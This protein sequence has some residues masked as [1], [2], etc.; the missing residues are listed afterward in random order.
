M[1]PA[2]SKWPLM[3]SVGN[4]EY[5]YTKEGDESK[6]PSGPDG[7]Y[8]PRWGNY[9]LDSGGE[10]GVPTA[11]RFHMP[12]TGNGVFWYSY[13]SGLVHTIVLSTEHDLSLH[14]RQRQ[15]LVED[16]MSVDRSR[17]PWVVL[18][19]HRPLY[20]GEA[21]WA[22]NNVGIALRMEVEDVLYDFRVDIVLAGHYHAYHRTYVG[23]GTL[24]R[25]QSLSSLFYCRCDGLY[26]DVCNQEG[27]VHLTIG[28]AGAR[29]DAANVNLL[30]ESW[31]ENMILQTYGYGRITVYNA[32]ALHFQFIQHGSSDD[33]SA[34]K[35]LDEIWIKR[36]RS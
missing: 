36:E 1:E 26:R 29:L 6:D 27:P 23:V 11:K 21:I 8:E 24:W 9:G 14:S 31:T 30:D 18:E 17:T 2:A 3:V 5:D 28:T 25:P 10:C 7:P 13:D 35:V 20:E 16:L 34:G 15:W 32:T 22:N 33:A 12:E 4:H 19:V